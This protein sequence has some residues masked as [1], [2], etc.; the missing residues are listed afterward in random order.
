MRTAVYS[1]AKAFFFVLTV[2][3]L[4]TPFAAAD[5]GVL[6][7]TGEQAIGAWHIHYSRHVF[8]GGTPGASLM[9]ITSVHPRL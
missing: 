9:T 1:A 2:A 3:L 4:F 6:L 8:A 5:D 7:D